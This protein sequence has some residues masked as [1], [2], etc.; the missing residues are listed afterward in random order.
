MFSRFKKSAIAGIAA[1]SL[2]LAILAWLFGPITD[3]DARHTPA[4]HSQTETHRGLAL[5]HT[6]LPARREHDAWTTLASEYELDAL[7]WQNVPDEAQ[8]VKLN[9]D[10]D[11]WL[12]GT[13]VAIYIPQIDTTYHSTVDRIVPNEL[14]ATTIY[15]KPTKEEPVFRRLILTFDETNAMAFVLTHNG[16]WELVGE[17]GIGWLVSTQALKMKQDYSKPDLPNPPPFRYADAEYVPRRE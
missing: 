10:F 13:P 4:N 6:Q 17:H 3:S 11:D 9:H 15:A 8:F 2:L 14:G 5:E 12:L 7:R 16:S 1:I